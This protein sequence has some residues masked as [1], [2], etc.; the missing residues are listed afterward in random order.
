M[1][2]CKPDLAKKI[3][4]AVFPGVQGGPLQ[5]V[6]CAKWVA[7]EEALE[8]SYRDYIANVVKNNAAFC[9]RFIE[10][11][12]KVV[13]G[14]TDNHLFLVDFSE[15]HPNVTGKMVQE[16]LEKHG[17]IC[18]KNCVP[19]DKRS[20]FKTSGIRLGSP[21]MTS[22]GWT[23]ADFVKC[24]DDINSIVTELNAKVA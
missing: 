5:N 1:I 18:N 9:Q 11:G 23:A 2:F 15:T 17:I 21:A 4:S 22:H 14:G 10:N 16:E 20:P 8:P 12:Y 6:I 13:T 3:D 7:A 19:G 24:A